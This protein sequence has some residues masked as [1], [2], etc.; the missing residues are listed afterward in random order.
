MT[1]RKTSAPG[2][3]ARHA[4]ILD[5]LSTD[6]TVRISILADGF[7]VSAETIRRDVEELSARGMVRRTHGGASPAALQ[8]GLGERER[9]LVAER[10]RIG[11]AAAALVEEDAVVMLDAG[12][13]TTHFAKALAARGLRA[14]V[15]TNSLDA[16]L[17]AGACPA[18]RV[19]V[20]PGE[21]S[22][23]ERGLYGPETAPS[24]SSSG[25]G[26]PPSCSPSSA[27]C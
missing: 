21:L 26:S 4:A 16:A 1:R 5:A 18:L 7:G 22:V 2:K 25:T 3:A 6:P 24:K 8:P 23:A 15:P 10:A 27:S 14:T 17:A 20:A 11:R 9:V 19:V 12:S 13:T